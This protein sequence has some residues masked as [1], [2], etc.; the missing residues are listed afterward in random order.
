MTKLTSA[1]IVLLLLSS[2]CLAAS[3]PPVPAAAAAAGFTTLA[4]NSDFSQ[5]QPLGWFG[6]LGSGPR[7]TWYQGREGGD[8]GT[9]A[10]CSISGGSTRYKLVPDP[11]IG[12]LVFD[13]SFF[14]TDISAPN[15]LFTTI[16][17]VDDSVL[18]PVLGVMFPSNYYAEA[19][20]RITSTPPVPKAHIGGLWWAFW[21]GGEGVN[22]PGSR[23]NTVEV[24]HPEQHG[25]WPELLGWSVLNWAAGGTGG[26]FP[27]SD[28]DS[29]FDATTYH[30][31]GVRSTTDGSHG[32]ALCSYVDGVQSGCS[33]F[34]L[35]TEQYA[36]RK[37]LILSAGFKCYYFPSISANCL[38]IPI[39]SI[40]K[41]NNNN[42]CVHATSP[43]TEQNFW[44]VQMNISGVTG[45][46][47]INGSWSATPMSWF[48]GATDWILTGSTFNGT[49]TGGTIIH[50]PSRPFDRQRS[51][52][53]LFE[54]GYW[55]VLHDN[56]DRIALA[57]G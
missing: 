15:R 17:T 30:T 49:P 20:Y 32:I 51:C 24:D 35:Y 43:V 11:T 29:G 22:P 48:N 56:T 57:G 53:E 25:E 47:N 6:C 8:Y 1:A 9:P 34:T 50:N 14:A 54:L 27:Y 33:T 38:N 52:V 3:D 45:A 13:L 41:C 18:P 4:L 16:Q 28:V 36:E 21:Q 10:P 23:W 39:S 5:P 40:Y 19:T 37:F 2:P 44:Q 12:K 26:Y 7:H 55:A 31:Y 42:F 46:L